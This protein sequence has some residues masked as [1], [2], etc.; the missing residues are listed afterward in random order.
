MGL[1]DKI[2]NDVKK[3]GQNKGK[4]IY[5]REGQKTRVRFL[6]DME[7]GMEVVFHDSFEAGIN[8]P[9]RETFGKSCPYCEQEGLRTR[10]Q[11]I[12]S[13][14]DYENKE[15]KLIMAPVNN[16]SPVPALVALYDTYGTLTDR[17]YVIT[18]T[19][20][21]QSKTFSVIPMDKAKFRNDKAKPFSNKKILDLVN[22]AYPDDDADDDDDEEDYG[23]EREEKKKP[24]TKKAKSK[25]EDNDDEQL[26]NEYFGM[27]PKE[28]YKL[29]K[30]RDIE[31]EPKKNARYYMNLLEEW[32]KAQDDW[33]DEDEEPEDDEIFREWPAPD[34]P[35]PP[36]RASAYKI[37]KVTHKEGEQ[38]SNDDLMHELQKQNKAYLEKIIETQNLI[39]QKLA[40]LV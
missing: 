37:P 28:L 31:A 24:S 36:P 38:S 26:D 32:D 22:K 25:I 20:K 16:C 23:Y 8:V 7:E 4:F 39:L 35:P 6:S 27:T 30:E 14:W 2:K 17:D 33:G 19:G 29:C 11:Y 1:L 12:W 21:Q 15:V 10:S 34:G 40:D 5:F 9:C 18:Q 3:S 13:V